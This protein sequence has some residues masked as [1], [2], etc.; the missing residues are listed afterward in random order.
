MEFDAGTD[1]VDNETTVNL[2]ITS[3]RPDN[4]DK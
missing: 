2:T 3:D 1:T 4:S